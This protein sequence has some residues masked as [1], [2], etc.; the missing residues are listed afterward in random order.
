MTLNAAGLCR[1]L[2]PKT[3]VHVVV[4]FFFHILCLACMQSLCNMVK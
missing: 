2:I 1:F 3:E 4:F